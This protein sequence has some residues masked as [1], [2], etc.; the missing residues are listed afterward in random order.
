MS[1]FGERASML[2][3]SNEACVTNV[4]DSNAEV[5]NE[6]ELEVDEKLT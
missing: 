6:M 3:A 4:H 1:F 5:G 2:R